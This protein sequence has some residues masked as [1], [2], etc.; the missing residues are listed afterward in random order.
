MSKFTKG[1]REAATAPSSMIREIRAQYAAGRTQGWLCKNYPY[2]I[3]Q[4]GRIVRG[5]VW[6]ELPVLES[7]Q[8][9]DGILARML[10]VQ[11]LTDAGGVPPSPLDGGDAPSVDHSTVAAIVATPELPD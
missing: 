10:A 8:G 7:M 5:E 11:Q 4:I 9:Q 2:S 1:N 6:K 3:A